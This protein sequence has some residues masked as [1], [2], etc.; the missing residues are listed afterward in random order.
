MGWD[1]ERTVGADLDLDEV[2]AVYSSSGLGSRRPV[3]DRDRFANM[4]SHANLVVVCR[5]G[6]QLLG[7]AR[8]VS[9]FA[10]ATY[11]SDIAVAGAHQRRGI[12]R[13]LIRETLGVGAPAKLILLAAPDA[14]GYYPRLG[15][16]RHESAWVLDPAAA[17]ST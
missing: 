10:Y 6:G 16:A 13:A 15:F 7:I 11:L 5:E 14:A 3:D 4:V 17:G 8:S 1:V 9:D 12:G 2:L